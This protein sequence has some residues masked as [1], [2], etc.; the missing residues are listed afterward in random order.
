MKLNLKQ[1]TMKTM[2]MILAALVFGFF[3]TTSGNANSGLENQNSEKQLTET[4]YSLV[5][6]APLEDL[7]E[8]NEKCS[9]DVQFRINRNN[10]ITDVKVKG[11]NPELVKYVIRK[12]SQSPVFINSTLK[13]HN[14]RVTLFFALKS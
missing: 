4:I 1:I 7:M 14:F 9:L 10:E 8:S 2:T 12:L 11:E 5:Q 13:N 6:S 3:Y